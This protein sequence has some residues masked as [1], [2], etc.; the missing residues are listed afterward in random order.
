MKES[1]YDRFMRTLDLGETFTEEYKN[2]WA[3]E[4]EMLTDLAK[5]TD[6]EL[7]AKI[8]EDAMFRANRILKDTH[9]RLTTV[10]DKEYADLWANANCKMILEK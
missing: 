10:F 8:E 5:L 9:E 2:F 1:T 7:D 4:D 6:E 3:K